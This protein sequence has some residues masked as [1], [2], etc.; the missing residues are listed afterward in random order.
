MIGLGAS[1][2]LGQNKSYFCNLAL[3]FYK[4]VPQNVP[5]SEYPEESR[6]FQQRKIPDER[7]FNRHQT[8]ECWRD[9]EPRYWNHRKDRKYAKIAFLQN[10]RGR[11]IKNIIQGLKTKLLF[12]I[13]YVFAIPTR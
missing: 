10:E 7:H 4:A 1:N 3:S 6:I 5:F 9:D 12:V 2:R 13:C 8:K 11:K